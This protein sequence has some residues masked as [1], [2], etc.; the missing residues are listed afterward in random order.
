MLLLVCE[1][2]IKVYIIGVGLDNLC[3]FSLFNMG[4]MNGGN[5]DESL[6]KCIVE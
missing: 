6:L 1:E 5:F 3:G 4:G 2:G